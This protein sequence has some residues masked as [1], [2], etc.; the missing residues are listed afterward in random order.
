LQRAAPSA[1]VE[2]SRTDAS[3]LGIHEGDIVRVTS[4]RGVITVPA[5]VGDVREGCVFAPFHYGYW[6]DGR[7]GPDGRPTAANE[8]TMT[9]WDPVSK[10]PIY[11]V[12]A[13]R[14]EKVADGAAPAPAPTNTASRPADP[15]RVP[16]TV[17]GAAGQADEVLRPVAPPS[18]AT[19]EE[20]R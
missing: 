20:S 3:T 11:K 15:T 19:G 5:R 10:Q 12:A 1:W 18:V 14:V 16:A 7:S 6:D 2:L 17:G 8:L 4:P 13:V 9:E